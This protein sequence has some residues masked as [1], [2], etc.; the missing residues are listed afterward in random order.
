MG[1]TRLP[2]KEHGAGRGGE[3][4][5]E[6]PVE[7]PEGRASATG[8]RSTAAPGSRVGLRYDALEMAPCLCGPPPQT[9]DPGLGLE[10]HQ[11]NS[12]RRPS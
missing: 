11:A 10:K 5:T 7:K 2:S 1:R 8:Q 9:H 6:L 4:Q 3:A 12:D